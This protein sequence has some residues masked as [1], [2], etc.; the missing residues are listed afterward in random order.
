LA[1]ALTPLVKRAT[2]AVAAETLGYGCGPG[3]DDPGA[4]AELEKISGASLKIERL[5]TDETALETL[6]RADGSID[7][8]LAD[9]T[10]I[11]RAAARGLVRPL[12]DA[13]TARIGAEL[14][15]PLRP[16]FAPLLHDGLGIAL[17]VRWGWIGPVLDAAADATGEW[18]DYSPLF[19]L[20]Y[21]GRI[22]ALAN[23]PWLPFLLMQ[24][25]GVDPFAPLDEFGEGEFIRVLRAFFKNEPVLIGKREAA[26]KG[27]GD[28]SLAAVVGAGSQFAAGLR[29]TTGG[30]WRALAPAPRDGMKQ[31]LLWV[32]AAAIHAASDAPEL[33]TAALAAL[34]D[35][36][37]ARALS[38]AAEGPAP[39]ASEAVAA[40][41]SA[42]ERR[43][44]Q[45]EDAEAAWQRGRLR[46][47]VPDMPALQAIW[48]K[49]R[50]S[51][52]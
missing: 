30:D 49:E 29:R 46:R 13:A 27:L 20:K 2:R 22:G 1:G 42:E 47:P 28:G 7:F 32:E 16:P 24:H 50:A 4:L 19:E 21:R 17:P 36:P 18:K 15:P 51:A 9:S 38:L 37:V 11:E 25:A 14:L 33:A 8:F 35:P 23:G 31:T 48:E 12:T 43:L 52:G 41:Y 44:L 40:A 45:L 10:L 39:S 26:A 3:C 6:G 5:G 34:F